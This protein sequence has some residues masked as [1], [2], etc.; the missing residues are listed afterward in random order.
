MPL[1]MTRDALVE[2]ADEDDGIRHDSRLIPQT[3]RGL[4]W[5]HDQ[6]TISVDGVKGGWYVPFTSLRLK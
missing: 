2:V 1:G 3:S 6:E 4:S 5:I